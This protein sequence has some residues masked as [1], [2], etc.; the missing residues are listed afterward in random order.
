MM[1]GVYIILVMYSS[2]KKIPR[3]YPSMKRKHHFLDLISKPTVELTW[4]ESKQT[5]VLNGK[6]ISTS[7]I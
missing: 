5:Q 4:E 3:N 2:E 7:Y 6:G 1:D